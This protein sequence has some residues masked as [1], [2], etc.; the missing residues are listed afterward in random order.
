MS[1]SNRSNISYVYPRWLQI[2]LHLE[3]IA[4]SLN[5]FVADIREYLDEVGT[6]MKS[7]REV[8]K[9]GFTW[10][11]NRQLTPI[12]I[13]AYFLHLENYHVSITVKQQ[14]QLRGL[15]KRFTSNHNNALEQF[16][17]FRERSSCFAE[18]SGS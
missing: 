5:V 3:N 13:A 16:L 12:H 18:A 15:S 10:Q 17:D 7:N 6:E 9:K 4:N 1:E 8:E 2:E 11:R 14:S